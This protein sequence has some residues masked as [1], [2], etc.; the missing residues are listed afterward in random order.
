MIFLFSRKVE[1][2]D[3]EDD[4]EEDEEEE[5]KDE[6]AEKEVAAVEAKNNRRHKKGGSRNKKHSKSSRAKRRP[7]ISA[8]TSDDEDEDETSKSR[9]SKPGD[10]TFQSNA[11]ILQWFPVFYSSKF[12]VPTKNVIERTI[13]RVQT[14]YSDRLN[15]FH[16]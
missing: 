3:S 4:E 11:F 12:Y 15:I 13:C 5:D 7:L 1:F 6:E 16:L 9:Q 14:N 8:T 10:L 2:K